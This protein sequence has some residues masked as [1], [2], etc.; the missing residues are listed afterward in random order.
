MSM[1]SR[2]IGTSA[3]LINVAAIAYVR[4][5]ETNE[6]QFT[7]TIYFL[8]D[9]SDD[10]RLDGDEARLLVGRLA[11]SWTCPPPLGLMPPQKDS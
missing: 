8:N 5:G 9:F 6:G 1:I 3:G 10:I 11:P 4:T 2:F 7:V